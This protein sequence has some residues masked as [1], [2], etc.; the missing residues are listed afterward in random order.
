MVFR[1]RDVR[2]RSA[3]QDAI[4]LGSCSCRGHGFSGRPGHQRVM[5]DRQL[6][7]LSAFVSPL[8]I[9]GD[10]SVLW[11]ANPA[12]AVDAAVLSRWVQPRTWLFAQAGG[13]LVAEV[14]G[15]TG[16][17]GAKTQW[18]CDRFVI[19]LHKL[20]EVLRPLGLLFRGQCLKQSM[21]RATE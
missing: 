7:G 1:V 18:K 5:G 16:G 3:V 21:Q 9:L 10:V 15:R 2:S 4:G 12:G 14:P 13:Q 11:R 6:S 19:R 17:S 20:R 8:Q